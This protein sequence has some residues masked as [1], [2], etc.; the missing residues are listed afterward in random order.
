[1]GSSFLTPK[2]IKKISVR[3]LEAEPSWFK[4]INQGFQEEGMGVFALEDNNHAEN[5]SYFKM[6]D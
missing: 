4:P 2:L 5:K 6:P 1:M 3:S